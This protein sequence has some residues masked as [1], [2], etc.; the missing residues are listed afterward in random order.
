MS[1][2]ADLCMRTQFRKSP[3]RRCVEV[4]PDSAI[5]LHPGPT[6]ADT[7]SGCALCVQAC[8]TGAFSTE[9][10]PDSALFRQTQALLKRRPSGQKTLSM[11][12]EHAQRPIGGGLR[13]PCLGVIG[14]NVL[15]GAALVGFERVDLVRGNCEACRLAAGHEL[16]RIS[17]SRAAALARAGGLGELPLTTVQ[18]EKGGSRPLGRR[19]M[20][21]GVFDRVRTGA[22]AVAEAATPGVDGPTEAVRGAPGAESAGRAFLRRMLRGRSWDCSGAIEHDRDLP[23]A[24]VIADEQRCTACAACVRVCPTG[25]LQSTRASQSFAL[26]FTPSA[27]INCS[28]CQ[29][30]C[31]SH[32]IAFHREARFTD[33]LQDQ[34]EVIVTVEMAWCGVCGESMPAHAGELCPTCDRRQT[35]PAHLRASNPEPEGSRTTAAGLP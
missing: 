29:I 31:P 30:A 27:C 17:L 6:I 12:C 1:V 26:S 18:L 5:A 23:W 28:L 32:A 34:S 24:R 14:E 35:V 20:F 15:F 11:S 22:A 16:L 8:P 10:Y 7:C 4:C 2:N 9:L 13:L 33:L 3:C 21:S 25:A 19:Q